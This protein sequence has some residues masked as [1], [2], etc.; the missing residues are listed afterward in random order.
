LARASGAR[1]L[2]PSR[3]Q[4]KRRQGGR[5]Q[6]VPAGRRGTDEVRVGGGMEAVLPPEIVLNTIDL[7][8]Y[9][10]SLH[11]DGP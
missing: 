6:A 3:P 10:G 8:H 5:D 11:V 4:R 7:H 9:P 2:H 1:F